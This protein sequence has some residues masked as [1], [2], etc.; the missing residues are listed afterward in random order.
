MSVRQRSVRRRQQPPARLI[1]DSGFCGVGN[2]LALYARA[3]RAGYHWADPPETC[4]LAARALA[5]AEAGAGRR[6]AMKKIA[7]RP[8]M[9]RAAV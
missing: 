4:H 3:P 8:T 9:Q 7:D 6:P 1:S 5:K 2:N